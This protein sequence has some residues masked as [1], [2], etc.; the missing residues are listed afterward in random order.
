[1]C[2]CRILNAK[3]NFCS[4]FD[5]LISAVSSRVSCILLVVSVLCLG[6]LLWMCFLFRML[7]CKYTR[8]M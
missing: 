1:M 7:I 8:Q 6:C 4:L 5:F 2:R 3:Y